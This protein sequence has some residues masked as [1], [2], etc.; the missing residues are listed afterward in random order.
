MKVNFGRFMKDM[1]GTTDAHIFVAMPTIQY[2]HQLFHSYPSWNNQN[3][4]SILN[5]RTEILFIIYYSKTISPMGIT[6]MNQKEN[7]MGL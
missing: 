1:N 5:R 6:K 7:S 4:L 2:A 3:E